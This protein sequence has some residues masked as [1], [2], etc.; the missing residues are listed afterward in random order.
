[1]SECHDPLEHVVHD[2]GVEGVGYELPFLLR[3]DETRLFEEVQVMRYAGPGDIEFLYNF[4]YGQVF[5]PEELQDGA[6][7]G[8]V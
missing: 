6:T 7:R 2:R 3:G 4:P 8:V 5:I 1:M